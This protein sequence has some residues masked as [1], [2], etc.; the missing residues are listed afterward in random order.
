MSDFEMKAAIERGH[1]MRYINLE[2]IKPCP[3]CGREFVIT[4]DE[5]NGYMVEHNYINCPAQPPLVEMD[6]HGYVKTT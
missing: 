4:G 6:G 2:P 1:A 5:E 3:F